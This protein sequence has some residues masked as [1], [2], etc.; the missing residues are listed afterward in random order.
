MSRD[1]REMQWPGFT[2]HWQI[3]VRRQHTRLSCKRSVVVCCLLF[4]QLGLLFAN[5]S[6]S[7]LAASSIKAPVVISKTELSSSYGIAES[8]ARYSLVDWQLAPSR[9]Q[10]NKFLIR[11]FAHWEMFTAR[12]VADLDG[13][14]YPDAVIAP[15]YFKEKEAS[16]PLH[17]LHGTSGP[18]NMP[19][20]RVAT[21]LIVG[22]APKVNHAR[23]I[24]LS[25]FNGDSTLD[26]FVCAHGYDAPPFPGTTNVLMLSKNKHWE[27]AA[28]AWTRDVGYQHGCASGD[29]RNANQPDIFVA[30]SQGNGSYWLRND[31]KGN[32]LKSQSGLPDSIARAV[33]IAVAEILD[34][35]GDGYLDLLVGG[36]EC[37]QSWC[38]STVVFWGDGSGSFSD[39]KATEISPHLACPNLLGFVAIDV[40][41]DGQRDLVVA[42]ARGRSGTPE[43]YKGYEIQVLKRDHRKLT[44][45]S[46][47]ASRE[48]NLS[49]AFAISLN[50]EPYWIENI[51]SYDYDHDG[52]PD[53]VASSSD[54]G[55]FFAKNVGGR[56]STWHHLK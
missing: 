11:L 24:I 51:W 20:A 25:D 10:G 12:A 43:F 18:V 6:A 30:N 9:N 53:L 46:E 44:D 14:G 29:V 33:N 45:I 17:I 19:F 21:D 16:R 40:D 28:Q 42:R 8:N 34:L 48:V 47:A 1:I 15:G 7:Q 36:E 26:F 49:A 39:D 3:G 4:S 37:P 2:S 27:V 55:S 13:D 50:G 56:F 35:D 41:G 5:S 52:L 31:G 22:D 38:H 32:F 23:K 54:I